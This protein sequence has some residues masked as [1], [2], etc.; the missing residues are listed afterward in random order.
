MSAAKSDMVKHSSIKVSGKVQ[1]VFFRA[2]TQEKARELSINGFVRN[3]GDGS[4]FIE[5]EGEEQNMDRFIAWCRVGP[6]RAVVSGCDVR[7]G[8][9]KGYPGFSIQR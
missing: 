6:P 4:V 3:E 8:S 7:P 9:P 2:S 1:G 5:A